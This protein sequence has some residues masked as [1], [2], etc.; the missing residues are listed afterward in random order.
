MNVFRYTY[1]LTIICCFTA[2]DL[3]R[4]F[5]GETLKIP[6]HSNTRKRIRTMGFSQIHKHL[7]QFA[8]NTKR[9]DSRSFFRK[10]DPFVS[11]FIDER[12]YTTGQSE[13]KAKISA[14]T[15]KSNDP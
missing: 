14:L 5:A 13:C 8:K 12:N 4:S 3:T 10:S 6:V 9:P 7:M 11:L 1:A 2:K 15:S